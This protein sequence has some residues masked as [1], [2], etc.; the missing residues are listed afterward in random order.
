[1]FYIFKVYLLNSLKRI[2]EIKLIIYYYVL[3]NNN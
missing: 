3:Y 1:M 2:E